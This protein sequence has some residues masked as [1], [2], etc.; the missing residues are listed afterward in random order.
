M[1]N[2]ETLYPYFGKYMLELFRPMELDKAPLKQFA[3]MSARTWLW[4]TVS[5]LPPGIEAVGAFRNE[6]SRVSFPS[7]MK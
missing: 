5:E 6:P 4:D 1:A 2:A 7:R 3:L